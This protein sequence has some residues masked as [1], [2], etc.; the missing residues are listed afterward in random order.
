MV[1]CTLSTCSAVPDRLEE[2]VGEAEVEQVLHRP[3][4]EVVVDAE[5]RRLVESA[6][7]DLVER[8]RR[9]EVVAE[10]L[11]DDDPGARGAARLAELLHDQLEQAGRDGQ[12]VG[13]V[14]GGAEFLAEGLEGRRVLV[15][16]VDVAE[17]AAE[18]GERGLVDAA[19]LFEAVARRALR[20]SRSQPALAT[21]MTGTSRWPCLT[22][23]WSAGKIFLW[24]RSPV[25]PKNTNASDWGAPI[26]SSWNHDPL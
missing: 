22:I 17:Q 13:R 5:D 12:V 20:W 6:Q 26:V 8:L 16:A 3:L 25:A 2:R 7:E 14:L 18:L 15:V 24:A 9:V 21:P 23:A 11:L 1:I 4:A 10:R 19:V